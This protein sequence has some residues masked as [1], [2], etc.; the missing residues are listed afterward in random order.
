MGIQSLQDFFGVKGVKGVKK[1]EYN[2]FTPGLFLRRRVGWH[3]R[4]ILGYDL[5]RLGNATF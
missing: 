1:V 4:S 3:L 2:S 5:A